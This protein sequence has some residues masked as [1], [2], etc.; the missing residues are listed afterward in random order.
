MEQLGIEPQ[1]ILAQIFNF[2]V[3]LVILKVLLYKPILKSLDERRNKIKEGLDY[4]EKMKIEEE[5]N[6][7]KREDVLRK[8]RSEANIIV[9]ESK[10]AGKKTENE[11]IEKALKE[12][13]AI[14]E[15]AREE[16]ENERKEMEKRLKSETVELA[17]VWVET[18]L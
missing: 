12:K 17:R 7:K 8:A 6:A 15:K 18:V 4:A 2:F 3:L 14:I 11:I 9:E 13:K 16:A 10:K 1:Q 5:K